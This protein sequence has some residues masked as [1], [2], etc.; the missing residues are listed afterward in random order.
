[1]IFKSPGI[2]KLSNSSKYGYISLG[3]S[4]STYFFNAPMT[5]IS[6]TQSIDYNINKALSGNFSMLTF[7]QHPVVIR[8]SGLQCVA[9]YACDSSGNSQDKPK[10]QSKISQ[11]FQ[12]YNMSKTDNKLQVTIAKDIYKAVIVQMK[13]QSIQKFPG[14]MVYDITM[15][16]TKVKK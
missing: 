3:D 11:F 15:Y 5:G 4:N 10:I 6:I 1:M 8:L 13:R 2:V 14:S 16:G 7:Q 9:V 12:R